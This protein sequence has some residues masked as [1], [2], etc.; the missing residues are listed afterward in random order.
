MK[1]RADAFASRPG[2]QRPQQVQQPRVDGNVTRRPNVSQQVAELPIRSTEQF[3]VGPVADLQSLARLRS[4]QIER[5]WP[6]PQIGIGRVGEIRRM[7]RVADRIVARQLWRILCAGGFAFVLSG[8]L[9]QARA[10]AQP[11]AQ[12][13]AGGD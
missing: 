12:A 5:T 2:L 9:A 4:D 10:A 6:P 8:T 11:R 1:R 3:A 7:L 13:G